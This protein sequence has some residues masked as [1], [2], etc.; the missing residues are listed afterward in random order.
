MDKKLI[1]LL[2][3]LILVIIITIFILKK[4][5]SGH[6]NLYNKFDYFYNNKVDYIGNQN[7]KDSKEGIKYSYSMM[8][9]LVN[10]P[11]NSIWNTDS[12]SPK[13]IMHSFGSPNIIYLR[14][15]NKLQIELAYRNNQGVLDLYVFDLE[16]IENQ[17]WINLVVTVNDRKVHVYKNGLLV[18]SKSLPNVNMKSA[19]TITIGEKNNNFNGY[20]GMLDY[21][22]YEL[23]SVEVNKIYHKNIKKIPKKLLS[24]EEYIYL[25]K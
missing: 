22:N 21:Y 6:K 20:F 11:A 19:K 14:K 18:S 13:T 12:D 8:F 5:Y 23:N 10:L 7:I 25:N 4:I 17:K 2:C 1:I 24:Y 16:N 15:D 3:V 9:Y